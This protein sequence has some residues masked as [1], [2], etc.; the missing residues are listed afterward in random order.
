MNAQDKIFLLVESFLP[1]HG[2]MAR[3]E[4][5]PPPEAVAELFIAGRAGSTFDLAWQLIEMGRF[6]GWGAALALRQ[7]SGRGQLRRAWFSPESNMHVSF[8]LPASDIFAGSAATVILGLLFCE[9]F[10][11]LGLNLG[12]KWPNDLILNGPDGPGKVG[13]ILLEEKNGILVAGVG[14]NCA[15]VPLAGELREEAALPP[16]SLP[17]NFAPRTPIRLWLR[18]VQLLIMRYNIA[19]MGKSRTSLLHRAED[20]LL[21]RGSEVF[22]S[23]Y[24]ESEERIRGIVTGLSGEGGLML[25]I[26]GA[27]GTPISREITSG[28]IA[29]A[30]L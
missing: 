30:R 13:G 3:G 25:L 21:W 20:R 7:D 29:E 10:D 1:E 27:G 2:P 28:S 4:L 5:S 19:F 22:L 16:V 11:S 24:S 14:I 23:G 12:L 18:L 26:R 6:P 8:R 17:E 9:A 15:Q